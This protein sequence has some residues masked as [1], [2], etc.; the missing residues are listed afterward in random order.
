V[1][2]AAALF[3]CFR[4]LFSSRAS[5]SASC[6]ARSVSRLSS[7]LLPVVLELVGSEPWAA[8]SE[9]VA[10]LLLLLA[11][12]NR[13]LKLQGLL[14]AWL[15]PSAPVALLLALDLDLDVPARLLPVSLVLL[16]LSERALASVH[17]PR[18]LLEAV[19]LPGGPG[20][21]EE[22]RAVVGLSGVLGWKPCSWPGTQV[23]E[24]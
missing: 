9:P 19:L 24:A 2:A 14:V 17:L 18:L 13:E 12:W 10:R 22:P 3:W 23:G 20:R 11:P 5:L 7:W 1:V 21:G 8:G 15:V 6:C 4:S 16:L